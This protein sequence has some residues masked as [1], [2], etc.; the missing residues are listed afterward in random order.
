MLDGSCGVDVVDGVDRPA[1]SDGNLI[2][3][4]GMIATWWDPLTINRCGSG[5]DGQQFGP[6]SDTMSESRR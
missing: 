5:P 3:T 6:M 4:G 1:T 2:A